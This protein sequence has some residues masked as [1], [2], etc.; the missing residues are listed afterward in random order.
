MGD[1]N[2]Q[3]VPVTRAEPSDVVP[4]NNSTLVSDS[5]V[6]IIS[7]VL[8]FVVPSDVVITGSDGGVLS[9]VC[10]APLGTKATVF[11]ARSWA[12]FIATVAVPSPAPIV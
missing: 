12:V 11:P 4:S 8:S 10:V 3:S 1:V 9:I 2:V 5:V 7:G 6:P